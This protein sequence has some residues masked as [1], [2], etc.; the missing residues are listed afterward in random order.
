M[1]EQPAILICSHGSRDARAVAE[2]GLVEHAL[3]HRFAGR[4]VASGYLEFA[5][6]SIAESLAALAKGGAKEIWALPGMLF[7]AMHMKTDIPEELDAFSRKHP[8]VALRFGAELGLDWRMLEAAKDRIETAVAAADKTMGEVPRRETL[9]VVVG[10][11]TSDPDANGNIAK[12]AR[13]LWDVMGFGW[14]ETGFSGLAHPTADVVMLRELQR[15]AF[16]RVLVFPYFL[17][18]G[19]L[20]D[21]IYDWADAVADRFP[22]TQVVKVPYLKDH[23]RVIDTFVERLRD[24]ERDDAGA[25]DRLAAYRDWKAAGEPL[26]GEPWMKKA[27]DHHHDHD[28]GEGCCGG[29]GHEHHHHHDEHECCGGHGHHHGDEHECCG[30][31]GHD[32]DDEHECCGGHGHDHGDEH[33]CCGG[34][35]H[36]D[37]EPGHGGCGCGGKHR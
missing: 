32:H 20:V 18:T 10:R 22:E 27:F 8:D 36:H 30:G 9:L 14:V 15:D 34:H 4:A 1:S 3:K 24:I 19:I 29:H 35:G 28:H 5:R 12:V 7:A 23:P 17:F 11:G 25:S 16:R 13:M 31:H 33:E 2:F 6:P 26:E 21:R 37:D